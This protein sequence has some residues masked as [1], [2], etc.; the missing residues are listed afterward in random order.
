MALGPGSRKAVRD[1]PTRGA[2]LRAPLGLEAL[3]EGD[4]HFLVDRLEISYLD[5][6]RPGRV[7]PRP[8]AGE[9]LV[10]GDAASE[11]PGAR[12]ELEHLGLL[13]DATMVTERPS[14]DTFRA[15]LEQASLLHFATHGVP[16]GELSSEVA[17]QVNGEPLRGPDA[18]DFHLPPGSLVV[19][20]ACDG[21]RGGSGQAKAEAF[22]KSGP[23]RHPYYWAAFVHYGHPQ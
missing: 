15:R 1:L 19:L 14:E 22:L 10:L 13:L 21:T 7:A 9:R 3:L 11:L 4:G 16:A 6:W 8:F 20:A 18:R 12:T 17:L 23:Y 2:S 5:A